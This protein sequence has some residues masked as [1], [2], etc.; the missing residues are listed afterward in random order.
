MDLNKLYFD[1]QLLLLRGLR[2]LPSR[3]RDAAARLLAGQIGTFQ[4]AL[5]AAG[6]NRW[7]TAALF[8]LAGTA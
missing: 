4:R 1:H 3:K 7:E 6:A 2:S 5:G 8:T